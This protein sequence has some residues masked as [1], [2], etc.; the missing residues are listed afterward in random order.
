MLDQLET[1]AAPVNL[2]ETACHELG[3]IT[4]QEGYDTRYVVDF[5]KPAQ[6]HVPAELL[7]LLLAP[8]RSEHGC[9]YSTRVYRVDPDAMLAQL[10]GGCQG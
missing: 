4:R 6:G 7:Q 8:S 9:V 5:R 2:H 1:D 10:G 3:V